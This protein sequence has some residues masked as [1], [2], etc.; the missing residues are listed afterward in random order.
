MSLFCELILEGVETKTINVVIASSFTALIFGLIEIV[1][2]DLKT[3]TT[4]QV[5]DL[6]LRCSHSLLA[7]NASFNETDVIPCD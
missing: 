2:Q 7:R 1:D 5:H 3:K 4:P 6:E